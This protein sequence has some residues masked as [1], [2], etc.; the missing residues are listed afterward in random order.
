MCPLVEVHT[1]E[2]ART[3]LEC[4][5][6]VVGINNRDLVSFSVDLETTHRLRPL[7][8]GGV[9]VV[10]ESGIAGPREAGLVAGWGVDAV[11]VGEALVAA[12]D[13]AR[14]VRAMSMELRNYEDTHKFKETL[15]VLCASS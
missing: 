6:T 2:E 3:A 7:I 9:V 8:P 5:A 1:E 13:P 10:A 4:G 11:L 14:L 15:N 12:P